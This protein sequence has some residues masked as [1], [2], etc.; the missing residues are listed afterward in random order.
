MAKSALILQHVSFEGPGVLAD[1]LA[2]QGYTST[3]HDASTAPI[4]T[5]DPLGP[6]LLIVLG[7]PIGVYDDHIYP[8]LRS[9]LKLIEKRL[10]AKR[11]ILGICLGAQLIAH[12]LGKRV[13]AGPQKE[14]GWSP[15]ELTD[16]GKRSLLKSLTPDVP[17]LH[18]HGDTFDLPDEAVLL[19]ST[20]VTRNQAFSIGR[21]VLALQFHVECDGSDIKRWLVG[22]ACELAAAKIDIL[23]LRSESAVHGPA[24]VRRSVPLFDAWLADIP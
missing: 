16:A 17:V 22:H 7:G 5:L 4:D 23:K 19:A 20:A 14:I 9:E 11:P 15:L 10:T 18:W 12:A 1:V 13:Y 8:F 21:H 6:D 3:L 2:R 24:L